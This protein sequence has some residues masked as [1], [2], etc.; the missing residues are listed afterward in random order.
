MHHLDWLENAA[1]RRRARTALK[2]SIAITIGLY[3][4]PFGSLLAYPLLLLS[5]LFHELGHG[6]LAMCTGGSFERFVLFADGSGMAFNTGVAQGVASALV[7]A[8]GLVGPALVAAAAF[9]A[10]RGARASRIFLG[11]IAVAL[12]VAVALVVRNA[13]GIAF[14]ATVALVLGYIAVRTSAATAQLASVFLATQLA[15]SVFSRA[16]YLFT[17]VA[18]TGAGTIPS[19]TAHMA[20]ALG[21]TYW[22]WGLACGAFSLV[23]LLGGVAWFWR[24]LREPARTGVRR[25]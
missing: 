16:D 6:V 7:S 13:F 14:T 18:H 1:T 8:G 24:V 11:V 5:T 4:I 15:L 12:L 10:G 21:G 20:S 23:V 19:D 17:D 3:L 22:M 9:A 2:W 25:R